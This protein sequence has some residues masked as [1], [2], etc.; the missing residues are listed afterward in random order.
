VLSFA[1][2]AESPNGI[3][4]KIISI[5]IVFLAV[6]GQGQ[7]HNFL[8]IGMNRELLKDTSLW[9]SNTFEG[10]QIAYSWR[11]L[12][13]GKDE[14][15]FST[16]SEDLNLLTKHRK[17]L[18]IQIQDVSFSTKYIHVPKYLLKDSIYH[19][20]VNLQYQFKDETEAEY[21]EAGWVARRWDPEV[22]KRLHRFYA[23][24][25]QQFDGKIEGVNTEETAV[26]FGKGP[27]HPPGFTFRRYTNATIENLAALKKAF[28][29]S[30]VIVY[31]NF[32]PGGFLPGDSSH[33][34]DV[35]QFA[36]RNNIGAG[37]PDL[38]PYKP[39]QMNNSYGFIRESSQK[40]PMGVAVQDGTYKY[41]N[42][43]TKKNI[44]AEEIYQFGKTY[45]GL[46]YIF[47][48]AEEPFLH[49]EIIPFLKSL[50]N[51]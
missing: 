28:P 2:L 13:P 27:L 34:K 49:S 14:Y 46:K 35:Y 32:M 9:A 16:V 3:M 23:A 48:G 4:K 18:F 25:G 12:E 26:D 29:K 20:G 21:S 37:G 6:Q 8:F 24:L 19:G 44:R 5:L 40:V 43:K 22:Q 41:I 1:D 10:V 51:R 31:A 39:G 15:D 42:P 33:L 17:K 50:R 11:Q 7:I 47:W 36:W 38:L 45:L 30:V